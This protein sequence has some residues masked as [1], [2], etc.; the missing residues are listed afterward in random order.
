MQA[1][2]DD[3]LSEIEIGDLI[4]IDLGHEAFSSCRVVDDVADVNAVAGAADESDFSGPGYVVEL[5][6]GEELVVA[7][8]QIVPG[9]KAKHYFGERRALTLLKCLV[10]ESLK[11]SA[12]GF[13][14]KRS[15]GSMYAASQR[16]NDSDKTW[17]GPDSLAALQK[18]LA[19]TPRA[20]DPGEPITVARTK[21]L[22]M[23]RALC[24]HCKRN[25]LG[26]Y[27]N[28][29]LCRAC[30]LSFPIRKQT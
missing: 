3:E 12:S 8:S 10:C 30:E 22:M 6:S 2:F 5:P 21:S 14:F 13:V 18:R 20:Y 25:N 28:K 11:E 23:G 27:G 29:A 16:E 1:D 15:D 26:E 17:C 19:D 4:D 7:A 9:S 24:P